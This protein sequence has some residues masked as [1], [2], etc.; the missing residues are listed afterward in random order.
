[1]LNGGLG[2]P[3]ANW[4][5][6]MGLHSADGS[7]VSEVDG[8]RYRRLLGQGGAIAQRPPSPRAPIHIPSPSSP[9]TGSLCFLQ[10][11]SYTSRSLSSTHH[12]YWTPAPALS[13]WDTSAVTISHDKGS[14]HLTKSL[15]QWNNSN[16]RHV[17]GIGFLGISFGVVNSGIALLFG[18][19][20]I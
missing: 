16:R 19:C 12:P 7:N 8:K 4:A 9:T 3:I 17:T 5:K 11:A 10:P 6:H 14:D 2:Q 13:P 20:L 18:S 15:R 1:M